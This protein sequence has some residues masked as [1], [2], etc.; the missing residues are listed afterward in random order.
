MSKYASNILNVDEKIIEISQ[1]K[2]LLRSIFLKLTKKLDIKI[3][4][5]HVITSDWHLERSKED[6]ISYLEGKMI[7][8]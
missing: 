6:L 3:D 8:N 2:I 4:E 1:Q 7:E 5:M